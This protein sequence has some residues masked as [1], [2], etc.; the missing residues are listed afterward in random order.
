M[1]KTGTKKIL[2]VLIVEDD[3]SFGLELEMLVEEIGCKV[4]GLVDNAAGAL[5]LIFSQDIDLILMDVDIKGALN[6]IA[7]GKQIRHLSI[8]VLFITGM[9]TEQHYEE[10]LMTD[11]IGYLVKP[12]NKYTLRTIIDLAFSKLQQESHTVD[13]S[14]KKAFIGDNFLLMRRNKLY[15]KVSRKDLVLI[16]G[17][18]DYVKVWTTN[19]T[20][21]LLRQT[22]KGMEEMLKNRSFYRIHRSYIINLEAIQAVDFVSGE[23]TVLDR[24]IPINRKSRLELGQMMLKVE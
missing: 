14:S 4:V 21:Y 10:A 23:V 1:V 18:S 7:I 9:S 12:V 24:T 17:A 19:G 20:S 13:H 15:E 2:S 16:E 22:M 8:P 5:E 6:G 11:F 3:P